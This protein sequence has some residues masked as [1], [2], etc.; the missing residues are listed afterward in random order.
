MITNIQAIASQ[1]ELTDFNVPYGE[2]LSLEALIKSQRKN[3]EFYELGSSCVDLFVERGW[4]TQGDKEKL[5]Y[6]GSLYGAFLSDVIYVKEQAEDK[7][8]KKGGT[9]QKINLYT[10]SYNVM[11]KLAETNLLKLKE[12]QKA[13]E[14]LEDIKVKMFGT[15]DP[16]T[17][18]ITKGK[19]K[20]SLKAG[21]TIAAVRLDPTLSDGKMKYKLTIPRSPLKMSEV[22]CLPH[23]IYTKVNKTFMEN[24]K[25]GY[26][27]VEI[28][29]GVVGGKESTST[30]ITTLKEKDLVKLYGEEKVRE[31][32]SQYASPF[33]LEYKL[34]NIGASRYTSA[35]KNMNLMMISNIAYAKNPALDTRGIDVDLTQVDKLFKKQYKEMT[36]EEKV[37][38]KAEVTERHLGGLTREFYPNEILE[39]MLESKVYQF[40]VSE[41]KVDPSTVTSVDLGGLD[42]EGL[43]EILL[44]SEHVNYIRYINTSGLERSTVC[45]LNR[46]VLKGYLGTAYVG[47]YESEGVKVRQAIKEIQGGADSE[48]ILKKLKLTHLPIVQGTKEDVISSLEEHIPE[49]K[50]ET[51]VD[52]LLVRDVTATVTAAKGVQGYYVQLPLTTNAEGKFD[53]IISIA[54]RKL[55]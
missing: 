55:K 4:C 43:R 25:Q 40:D 24:L 22:T 21:D 2:G 29:E 49:K 42:T 54:R 28:K 34:P 17:G 35:K 9:Y 44:D 6:Q 47:K 51:N 8:H 46:T 16:K 7:S 48:A 50:M 23:S 3:Q 33:K 15:P 5:I 52:T 11:A 10:T 19:M 27:K 20:A 30:Y 1:I 32:L 26:A 41:A 39:N 18:K 14:L 36:K 45:T 37:A 38:F 13:Q 31:M 53:R 12:G